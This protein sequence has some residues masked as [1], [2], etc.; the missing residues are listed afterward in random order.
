M[1]RTAIFLLDAYKKTLSK[2]F[3]AVF[4][5]ACRYNPTCSE[6]AKEAVD[7]HGVIPGGYMSIK[8]VLRCHPFSKRDH[9]DPVPKKVHY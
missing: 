8:R 9:F 3:T 5:Q 4:G 1:K 2:F 7:K 6:Y